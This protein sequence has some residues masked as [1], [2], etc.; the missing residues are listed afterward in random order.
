MGKAEGIMVLAAEGGTLTG[1]LT[2]MG[3]TVG[4]HNGTVS[5]DSFEFSVEI[6]TPMGRMKIAVRGAVDGDRVSGSFKTTFGQM[7]FEGT[8][9]TE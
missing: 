6:H 9:V 3:S 4:I 1:S 8:R 2:G 7:P 5:G